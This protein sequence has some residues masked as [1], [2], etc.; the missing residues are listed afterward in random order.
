MTEQNA[1]PIEQLRQ[2]IRELK[3]DLRLARMAE[4]LQADPEQANRPGIQAVNNQRKHP[5]SSADLQNRIKDLES[6]VASQ[7]NR[8]GRVEEDLALL[9]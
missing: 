7:E 4:E 2:T 9:F 3:Q 6:Q 1:N 8:P 5:G